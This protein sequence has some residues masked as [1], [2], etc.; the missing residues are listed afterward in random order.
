MSRSNARGVLFDVGYTLLD[1][2]PRLEAGLRW[3]AR[4]LGARD[5]PITAARLHALYLEQCLAPRQ[6]IGG[7][8]V[9]TV[10]SA[11]AGEALAKQQRREI[12]WD[13][14]GMP[15]MPGAL[16][17]LRTLREA[18]LRVGVL[19][20][21]PAS[22][23]DDLERCGAVPL[24][25]DVWLSE[26]V[27]LEKPDPAFFRLALARWGLPAERVAYVGDRPDND[28]APARALGMHTVR[29]LLGPHARQPERTASE[30]ADHVASTLADAARHLVLWSRGEA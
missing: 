3:L 7:V 28:V 11:G 26:A 21:Q 23:R 22:A 12:P 20:N 15:P 2:T 10:L 13:A 18:G 25:D 6:G 9:Q 24:L 19:A 5:F 8:L 1:E 17:A 29:A 14:V 4:W 30:R 16:E 27:G